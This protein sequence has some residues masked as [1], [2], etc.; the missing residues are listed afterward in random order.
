VLRMTTVSPGAACRNLLRDI[1]RKAGE[2]PHQ[3]FPLPRSGVVDAGYVA[4][5]INLGKEAV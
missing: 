5:F 2:H 1:L 4:A 3:A